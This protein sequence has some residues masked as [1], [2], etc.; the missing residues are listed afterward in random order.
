MK[1]RKR[2][3]SPIR[4]P[5]TD[6]QQSNKT[7]CHDLWPSIYSRV[8]AS[9]CASLSPAECSS[10]QLVISGKEHLWVGDAASEAI[11]VVL[12]R[13]L[14]STD[15]ISLMFHALSVSSSARGVALN[16]EI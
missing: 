7:S 9:Y 11:E 12:L 13:V 3:L 16:I 10:W 8:E 2:L 6:G 14:L 15:D 1:L 4:L 5:G